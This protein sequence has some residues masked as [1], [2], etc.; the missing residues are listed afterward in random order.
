MSAH[1]AQAWCAWAGRR[2]PLEMEWACAVAAGAG[3][4]FSWGDAFEWVA[5][6]ARWFPGSTAGDAALEVPPDGPARV[7][8][9]ASFVT[10]ARCRHPAARRFAPATHDA[11]FAGFRSC[12]A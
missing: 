7:L 11:V 4:G 3:R 12:A 2:L 1:E 5:G 6:T 9:G 8:R 10:V